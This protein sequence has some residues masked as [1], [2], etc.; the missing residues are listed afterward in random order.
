MANDVEIAVMPEALQDTETIAEP[1]ITAAPKTEAP[2]PTLTYDTAAKPI[3]RFG[4]IN[5]SGMVLCAGDTKRRA[6]T[7]R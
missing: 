7:T 5:S 2:T 4:A 6:G 3:E 1:E